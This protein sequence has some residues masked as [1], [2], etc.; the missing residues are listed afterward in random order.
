ME[1]IK[2]YFP[3]LDSIQ[4]ERLEALLPLY[5]EWNSRINVISR[6]DMGNFYVHHVLH[7]LGI[8]KAIQFQTGT[9]VLDVGTG[10]GFP[11]IPLAILFPETEF[12]LV[13]SI[14]KKIKV[15]KEV[16]EALGLKNVQTSHARAE[17]I[18]GKFDFVVS[19]AVTTLPGFVL[20]VKDKVKP[21]SRHELPNGILYLK[22]GDFEDE[23]KQMKMPFKVFELS[24]WFEEPFFETKKLVHLRSFRSK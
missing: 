10:G 5:E 2:K 23:L 15:V 16:T 20:W 14:G 21:V 4:Y 9:R 1:A 13:D 19:R 6:K 24:H 12:L 3:G 18:A 11:G 17:D 7:S 22:G 8:A